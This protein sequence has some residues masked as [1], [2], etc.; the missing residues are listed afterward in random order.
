M[1]NKIKV[2]EEEIKEK[3]MEVL[4]ALDLEE[5]EDEGIE[6]PELAELPPEPPELLALAAA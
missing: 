6:L 5:L 3:L 1:E 4:G 2:T